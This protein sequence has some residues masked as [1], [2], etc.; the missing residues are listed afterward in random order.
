MHARRCATISMRPIAV[1]IAVVAALTALGSRPAQAQLTVGK[2][3][4]PSTISRG[5]TSLLTL[6]IHNVTGVAQNNVNGIDNLPSGLEVT[7]PVTSDCGGTL[8][9]GSTTIQVA[10]VT[11]AAG[12]SCSVSGLV[13]GVTSGMKV[14]SFAGSIT[15]GAT[16]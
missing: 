13:T 3:F 9:V 14:N 2:T 4:A 5:D 15:G 1:H 12:G 11:L 8:T 10:G 6:T 16:F 7:S